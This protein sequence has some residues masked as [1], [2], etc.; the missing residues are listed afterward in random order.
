MSFH[1]R[2]FNAVILALALIGRWS[3]EVQAQTP[4]P[5]QVQAPVEAP[6]HLTVATRLIQPFVMRDKDE[7]SGFSI[8]LWK[9]LAREMG[10][11]SRMV[12]KDT[13]PELFAEVREG[14]ADMAIS[15]IS[16][17]AERAR[18]YDFSQPMFDS[19]LQIMITADRSQAG[20]SLGSLFTLFSSKALRELL[21]VLV[22][23]I[24]L[25]VP[26]VWLVERRHPKSFVP[27]DKKRNEAVKSLWWTSS[28]LAGQATDMPASFLGRIIAVVWMFVGVV[29]VSYFTATVTASLTVKQL[30]GEISGPQDLVGKRVATVSSSTA[31]TYI[32]QLG[33]EPRGFDQIAQAIAALHAGTVDAVVYDAPVLQYHA[34]H[35]GKGKVQVSGAIFR[36]ETYG[37]MLPADSRLRKPVNEALLKLRESGEYQAI[38]ARW[39]GVSNDGN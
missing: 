32:R 26:F 5:T 1:I 30:T 6:S 16:I 37:I 27:S 17:T 34:I 18:I 11:N 20:S 8:D 10:V 3:P 14:R 29:F 7:L 13:L 38:H 39:F 2:W 25:P 22:I 33:V 19:G 12:V 31:F 15:A 35:E 9:A 24:A 36:P 21:I 28:T 4:S 23:L